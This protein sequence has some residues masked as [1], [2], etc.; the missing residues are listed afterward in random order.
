MLTN[1]P[2][3]VDNI[4]KLESE[5]LPKVK[6]IAVESAVRAGGNAMAVDGKHSLSDPIP[7]VFDGKKTRI[8][9]GWIV[10]DWDEKSDIKKRGGD[11]QGIVQIQGLAT[12]PEA[13]EEQKEA[14]RRNIYGSIERE[15]VTPAVPFLIKPSA[16]L[17]RQKSIRGLP[18]KI[19]QYGNIKNYRSA[20][21]KA[22]SQPQKFFQVPLGEKGGGRLNNGIKLPPGLYM[23]KTRKRKYKRHPVTGRKGGPYGDEKTLETVNIITVLRYYY[24]R[25]FKAKWDFRDETVKA[26]RKEYGLA[27]QRQ[28]NREIVKQLKLKPGG[29]LPS[30]LVSASKLR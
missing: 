10:W 7:V 9:R 26:M 6:S 25:D 1:L 18:F 3:V 21:K 22:T 17:L 20:M 2:K 19:D 28:L 11:A 12:T 24:I 27:F 14:I 30:N 8:R 16:K 5:V 4:A 15:G 13:R 23:R 29:A